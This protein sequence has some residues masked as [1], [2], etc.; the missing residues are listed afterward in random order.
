LFLAAT[1]SG[2]T[3]V[4]TAG[5][6][7]LVVNGKGLTRFMAWPTALWVANYSSDSIS[8]IDPADGGGRA[9]STVGSNPRG[10]TFVRLAV[11]HP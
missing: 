4:G 9:D 10:I 5:G 3:V 7:A 8:R 2:Q 1:A 6:K 11:P